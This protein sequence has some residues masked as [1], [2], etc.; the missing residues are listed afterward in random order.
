MRL[1][2]AAAV[3]G[4]FAIGVA[5]LCAVAA[6]APAVSAQDSA[7]G[8]EVRIGARLNPDGRIE[9][10]AQYWS[11]GRWSQSVFPAQR[12]LPTDAPRNTWLGSSALSVPS[13]QARIDIGIDP[14]F[15]DAAGD[16]DGEFSVWIDGRRYATSCGRLDLR[17]DDGALSLSTHDALCDDLQPLAAARIVQALGRGDQELRVAARRRADN[18]IELGLQRRAAEAWAPLQQ[19]PSHRLPRSPVS[20]RWYYSGAVQ[21]PAPT[22]RLSADL[23]NGVDLAVVGDQF[24]VEIDGDLLR[25]HCGYL[26]LTALLDS[27][28][29]DTYDQRCAEIAAIATVCGHRL[30]DFLCDRQQNLLY[31][32]EADT[33]RPSGVNDIVLTMSEAQTVVDAIHADYFPTGFSRPPRV[34]RSSNSFAHYTTGDNLIHLPPWGFALHNLIHETAHALIHHARI[35]DPGHGRAYAALLIDTWERYLPFIDTTAARADALQIGVEI[36]PFTRPLARSDRGIATVRDTVCTRARQ[37]DPLCR[38]F[39]RELAPLDADDLGEAALGFGWRGGDTWWLGEQ[40]SANGANGA[41][42]SYVIRDVSVDGGANARAR[43]DIGCTADDRLDLQVWWRG[44]GAVPSRAEHRFGGGDW[45]ASPWIDGE[46]SWGDE[47]WS[48]LAALDPDAF[49]AQLAFGA[50]SGDDFE[51]R[52]TRS[53]RQYRARF[54]LRGLF[55]TPIQPNL[56][57]CG[58]ATA[59]ADPNAP[60]VGRGS[61]GDDI[62]WTAEIDD[63]T[64]RFVSFVGL[65]ADTLTPSGDLPALQLRC[66]DGVFDLGFY[67]ETG[68]NLDWSVAYRIGSAPWQ[69]EEWLAGRDVVGPADEDAPSFAARLSWAAAAGEEFTL[70]VQERSRPSRLHTAVFDLTSLFQTPIQPNLPRCGS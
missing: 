13:R 9:V 2:R 45:M 38:A 64:G 44:V 7:P 46:G 52:F 3:G 14:G 43:L 60:V 68:R 21:L 55:A 40:D 41:I 42:R 69:R 50:H 18:R 66:A 32:W 39:D 4:L 20:G 28:L 36:A 51:I 19:P 56:A 31:Q 59:Q 48:Y 34:V 61:L 30:P 58:A 33:L 1:S 24:V 8:V 11:N 57:A 65:R 15:W 17:L 49:I 70:Q 53:G 26:S 35:R 37:S 29:I 63:A 54:D 6:L 23:R 16:G 62:W 5:T 25:S 67:W 22:P 12:F 47:A 10:G 27:I